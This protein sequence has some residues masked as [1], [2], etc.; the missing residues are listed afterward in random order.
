MLTEMF[1]ARDA[2]LA[3]DRQIEEYVSRLNDADHFV[4]SAHSVASGLQAELGLEVKEAEVRRV[5]KGMGMRYRKV[6][7]VPLHAN[8]EMNLVLRQQWALKYLEIMQHQKVVLSIDESWVRSI[9]VL[10]CLILFS[11]PFSS[12]CLTSVDANG[13]YE[14]VPIRY[15][16]FP[17]H[18]GS[19]SSWPRTRSAIYSSACCRVTTTN[20]PTPS[21]SR[22]LLHIWTRT[23]P[24]GGRIPSCSK[25][26]L[27]TYYI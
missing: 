21:S 16:R 5:M 17:W 26:V 20:T 2:R 22:G 23:G 10:F 1:E 25:M 8:S 6:V 9:A 12:A 11:S 4:D 7:H 14:A 3:K 18:R 13:K 15:L 19:V 27:R 24:I